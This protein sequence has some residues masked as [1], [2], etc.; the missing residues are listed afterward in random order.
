MVDEEGAEINVHQTKVLKAG[1]PRRDTTTIK[2]AMEK[3]LSCLRDQNTFTQIREADP[4]YLIILPSVPVYVLKNVGTAK[5]NPK[6]R[7][8]VRGHRD[9]DKAF[10]VH[11]S[12]NLKHP[13]LRMITSV[14]VTLGWSPW[15][16][17]DDQSSFQCDELTR[18]IEITPSPEMKLLPNTLLL[19]NHY[20]YGISDSG[21]GWYRKLRQAI[22][23]KLLMNQLIGD[24]S[25]YIKRE[26]NVT[27][28]MV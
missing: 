2:K 1:D 16:R 11:D 6:F 5:E 10:L 17:D 27:I 23:R 9:Q 18:M 26:N 4:P 14:S 13:S 8:T 19:L 12:P 15:H 25:E 3:G 22:T 20:L 24:P 21:D 28:G 7:L